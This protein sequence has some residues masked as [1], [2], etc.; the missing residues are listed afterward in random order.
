M[1]SLKAVKNF[2]RSCRACCSV[3]L[4]PFIGIV[5]QVGIDIYGYLEVSASAAAEEVSVNLVERYPRVEVDALLLQL[6][7]LQ[8]QQRHVLAEELAQG[9]HAACPC[10]HVVNLVALCQE[11]GLHPTGMGRVVQLGKAIGDVADAHE[12]G[13]PLHVGQGLL[14]PVQA[15][16]MAKGKAF[17]FCQAVGR[18]QLLKIF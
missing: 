10:R 8:N 3:G 5:S 6:G 15:A 17:T 2:W 11:H 14:E 18:G 9:L 4:F 1:V 12:G 16:D 7:F 13:C